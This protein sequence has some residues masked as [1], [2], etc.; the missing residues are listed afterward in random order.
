[1]ERTDKNVK[2]HYCTLDFIDDVVFLTLVV[3]LL[4][5]AL[6]YCTHLFIAIISLIL[7]DF[8]LNGLTTNNK[9]VY[10]REEL[11]YAFIQEH[12]HLL[13]PFI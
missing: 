7:P 2:T 9:L 8:S 12:N 10:R 13:E 6:Q 11:K 5:S 1:M 4:N 3:T